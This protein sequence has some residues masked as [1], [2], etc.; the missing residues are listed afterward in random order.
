MTELQAALIHHSSKTGIDGKSLTK[1]S[2]SLSKKLF[3]S[4]S[5]LQQFGI[6]LDRGKSNGKRYIEIWIE[7]K[8]D[9]TDIITLESPDE[10]PF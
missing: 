4:Q 8:E 1:A 2:S 5:V 9:D 3:Q 7:G 10:L 6:Y